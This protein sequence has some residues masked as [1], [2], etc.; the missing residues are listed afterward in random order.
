MYHVTLV[1]KVY[2]DAVKKDV[3]WGWEGEER[4][5][6]EWPILCR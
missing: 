5:E 2:I 3:K 1:L 6:I 4:V